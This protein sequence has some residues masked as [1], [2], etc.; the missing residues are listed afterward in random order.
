MRLV[1]GTDRNWAHNEEFDCDAMAE[2]EERLGRARAANRPGYL[3][4]RAAT[5]L[6]LA[7]P[8]AT[9]VAVQ[10]L[11]RVV[12]DHDDFIEVPWSHELLGN[13]YLNSGDLAA[14]E[15]HLRLAISSADER[16]N[17]LSLPELTLAE[18]LLEKGEVDAA[19]AVLDEV[20]KMPQGMVWNS[21]LFRFAVASAHCVDLSGSDASSWAQ[22]A[23]DL[24]GNE[25]PQ[26]PR[27]PT[28]GLVEA[29]TGTLAEMRQLAK[30]GTSST[31]W[32]KRRN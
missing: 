26:L 15:R 20:R 23:L 24:A 2:F 31:K 30:T 25:E 11:R 13:A 17:G 16:R 6:G 3:R 8:T 28:I 32:W 9:A 12:D 1:G 4:V 22:E 5:L 14:A 10:L 27:H 29:E 21:Q 18:V 7:H 19:Q